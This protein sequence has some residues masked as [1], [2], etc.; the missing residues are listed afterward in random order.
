M[1]RKNSIRS[2]IVRD[3]PSGPFEEPTPATTPAE[4]EQELKPIKLKRETTQAKS[5]IQHKSEHGAISRDEMKALIEELVGSTTKS[6]EQKLHQ[7]LEDSNGQMNSR[8][9]AL[10]KKIDEQSQTVRA[11]SSAYKSDLNNIKQMQYRSYF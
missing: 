11:V 2:L 8:I 1:P 4:V 10:L 9:E 6:N 3:E 5:P 7:L